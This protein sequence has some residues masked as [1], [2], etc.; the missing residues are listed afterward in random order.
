MLYH[1]ERIHG[2]TPISLAL[3][4]PL[5]KK[6]PF[7]SGD[8]HLLS[9][10]CS[11]NSVFMKQGSL[12]FWLPR[13]SEETTP[14]N[15]KGEA[16]FSSLQSHH[17]SPR[18]GLSETHTDESPGQPRNSSTTWRVNCPEWATLSF[19]KILRS[20]VMCHAQNRHNITSENG[21]SLLWKYTAFR[22]QLIN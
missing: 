20:L 6:Q 1:L 13:I 11:W 21:L 9:L 18:W 19:N 7:G 8:R 16:V 22:N 4:W 5:T 15:L 14:L 3:S 2:P 12:E 10:R 17:N